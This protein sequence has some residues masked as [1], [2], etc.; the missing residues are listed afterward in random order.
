[1]R[2]SAVPPSSVDIEGGVFA[3]GVRV[4]VVVALPGLIVVMED[5]VT[6]QEEDL[7]VN[8]TALAHPLAV[9]HHCHV[10]PRR[11][12]GRVELIRNVDDTTGNAAVVMVLE[13]ERRFIRFR[14]R[15]VHI[16]GLKEQRSFQ[17]TCG[18]LHLLRY[19]NI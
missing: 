9:Q 14:E 11:Q 1:M 3:D 5:E 6:G 17:L 15:G 2:P 12:D 8:L 16:Q 19:E 18:R 7:R 13:E 4:V 10:R